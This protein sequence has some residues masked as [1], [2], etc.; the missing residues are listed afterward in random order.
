MKVKLTA[1]I[2]SLALLTLFTVACSGERA[3]QTASGTTTAES[4]P[5]SLTLYSGR[6]EKLIAPVLDNFTRA[7]GID[8]KVRYGDTAEL[9]ATLMEEGENSPADVFLAQDA[10]ALGAVSSAGMLEPLPNEAVA[11]V[12]ERFRSPT[13][14]WVGVSGRARTVVYNP[15]R[16]KPEELPQSLDALADPRYRGRFGVAPTNA[17]FQAHMAVYRVVAG[18][19]ALDTLLRGITANQP[20]R[21]PKNG[22]IVQAVADGEIDF[23]LVNHYYP[24]Q[25]KAEKQDLPVENFHMPQGDASSFVNVAGV[26]IIRDSDPARQLVNYLLSREAQEYFAQQTFEYPLIEG[27]EPAAVVTPLS[28]INTPSVD[29]KDVSKALEPALAA[30]QKSGLV[31]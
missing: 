7:T 21:Y 23:G 24:L 28:Q 14:E 22:A 3:D 29:M 8:V 25:A 30:I 27:V 9:A 19:E 10:G 6:N 1:R 11:R 15:A 12:P 18:A 5:T 13:G 20:K 2:T 16:I 31:Q 26:G 4:A 17:S